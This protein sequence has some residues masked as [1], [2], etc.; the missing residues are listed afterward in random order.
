MFA[1]FFIKKGGKIPIFQEFILSFERKEEKKNF[2]LRG[3]LFF[4][5]GCILSHI[6][7]DSQI[8]VAAIITLIV[9]D[10][11]AALYGLSLGKVKSPTNSQKHLD[12]AFVAATANTFFLSFL[13][14]FPLGIIFLASITAFFSESLIPFE[15]M[16][17]GI[18][19]LIIN[20]NILIPLIFGLFLFFV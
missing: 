15:K 16:E 13:L 2:P 7:F 1:S 18:L 11:I 6:I 12:A 4:V 8:A 19:G 5:A 17:M 14:S 3:A 9:G 10:T 20:D